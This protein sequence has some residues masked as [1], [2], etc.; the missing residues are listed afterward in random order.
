M[1]EPESHGNSVDS[2]LRISEAGWSV[3]DAVWA[4]A[5]LEIVR[6][7]D[8]QII[9]GSHWGDDEAGLIQ[10]RLYARSDTPV[11]SVLH[12]GSHWLLMSKQRRDALHTDAKGS[13]LEE[14]AVCYLQ[15]LLSDLLPF[16]GRHR[17]FRDMD[18]WG[19]SFRYGSAEAW[20]KND[21]EDAL[22][23][24]TEKLPHAHGIAGLH[25][26]AP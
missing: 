6:V 22:A 1:L 12:E 26:H 21:A 19:Y 16:M 4:S 17:M 23:Y 10:R 13:A 9:P 20:F 14:M 5:G 3:L 15:V 18:R 11:H 7:P 24:L 8:G 25:V 2:V